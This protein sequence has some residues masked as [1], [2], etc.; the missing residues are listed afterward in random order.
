MVCIYIW[1]IYCHSLPRKADPGGWH[2]AAFE[3]RGMESSAQGRCAP[4]RPGLLLSG[5]RGC[6]ADEKDGHQRCDL[7]GCHGPHGL[8]MK[9]GGG[10]WGG[11]G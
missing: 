4:C 2:P 10:G 5:R 7:A 3:G 1:C 8:L 9:G 6:Q 11:W